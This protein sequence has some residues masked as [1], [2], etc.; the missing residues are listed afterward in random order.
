MGIPLFAIE[1]RSSKLAKKNLYETLLWPILE[2]AV[3]ESDLDF[4]P[5]SADNLLVMAHALLVNEGAVKNHCEVLC[6]G[7]A[8]PGLPPQEVL[9]AEVPVRV[10]S[11]EGQV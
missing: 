1:E 11:S 9:H 8:G 7:D 5:P 6:K 2:G 10:R 3:A 4:L